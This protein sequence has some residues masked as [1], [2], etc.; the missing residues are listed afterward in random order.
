MP[1]RDACLSH[2]EPHVHPAQVVPGHVA[3]ELVASGREAQTQVPEAASLAVLERPDRGAL[4]RVLIHGRAVRA[5]RQPWIACANHQELVCLRAPVVDHE[6]EAA[7]G[8]SLRGIYREIVLRYA[9]APP[10]HAGRR[11]ATGRERQNRDEQTGQ[12]NLRRNKSHRYE[13][14]S[15]SWSLSRGLVLAF[16]QALACAPAGPHVEPT[17]PGWESGSW[18]GRGPTRRTPKLAIAGPTPRT[19][20]ASRGLSCLCVSGFPA[21]ASRSI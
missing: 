8:Q 6:V 15:E 11:A 2:D 19:A 12:R 7:G 14:V 5:Q 21:W 4:Q 16:A 1:A 10:G 13:S 20:A 9:H 17:P 18:K 3:E